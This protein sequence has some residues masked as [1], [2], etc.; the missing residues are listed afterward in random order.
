MATHSPPFSTRLRLAAV[1]A[2]AL[3]SLSVAG[4]GGS[5][6]SGTPVAAAVSDSGQPGS[7]DEAT[8]SDDASPAAI[9]ETAAYLQVDLGKLS[10]EQQATKV[11]TLSVRAR[12]SLVANVGPI[13]QVRVNGAVIGTVE[14][15][16]ADTWQDYSFSAPALKAGA[17]VDVVFDNDAYVNGVDRNLY[18]SAISDGRTL[19][20]PNTPIV[21]LDQ[22]SGAKA[23]DGLE[24]VPGR[25]ELWS[26][27]ALRTTWPST[28][29][30]T[31]AVRLRRQDASRFLMQTTFGPTAASITQLTK[32][33]YAS[34]VSAQMAL[35]VTDS[36]VAA[37]QTRYDRGP[38]FRPNGAQYS[39]YEVSRAFW[40][41]SHE[42]PDQL[43]RRVAYA[44]HQIFMVSQADSNLYHHSR[45]YARYLDL[46]NQHSFGNFRTLL[47]EMA[48]SPA[49][50]IYLSH[51]RNRKEDPA[52][53]RLPDE[54]F[55]REVMQ[56]FTIGLYELNPDGS[57]VRDAQGQPIETYNNADVMA[58]AK[59]FTGFS[60]AFPN[61]QLTEQKFRWGWPEYSASGD[62]RIDIL[63]MKAYPGQHSTAAKTLFAG[64]RW[65]VSM[66]AG[67]SAQDDLKAALDALFR[68]P[69]VGPFIG[70][71][72]IQKLVTSNPSPAYVARVSAVFNNNGQGVR[73]DL[74]AV[75]RAILLDTEARG[76]PTANFGKLREPVLRITQWRRAFNATSIDGSYNISWHIAPAG[77]RPFEAPS[78][79]GDFRPGYIP[80]NS[81]FAARGATAPEFQ[82]VNENTVAGW[83]NLAESMGSGG[84]GW[85]NNQR[86]INADYSALTKR[87]KAGQVAGML[88]DLDHWLFGSTMSAELRQIIID[89]ISGVQGN[90]DASQLNRARMAVFVA[91]A[92]P[93]FLI[94]R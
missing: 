70:R 35:P 24:V 38:T 71:Q 1:A 81:S 62:T 8:A 87:L 42:A 69:N 89:A 77:Q 31:D 46:L 64:K 66:P 68:H 47:E 50:G 56:L 45:A 27:G 80:P 33:T 13:M 43:R 14:V 37:V 7:S 63:P 16:N 53:D 58:L 91:M 79:F 74:G 44:L 84:L 36:F 51:M 17:K 23:F 34:W 61:N 60:W 12:G 21:K 54:N 65:A 85:S 4:C 72:L 41:T 32:Q 90:D 82:I 83:V 48:L 30:V 86:E 28:A 9:A 25:S 22:G 15:R 3:L 26:N 93:E 29:T 76:M 11:P 6:P 92:S 18:V 19:V 67:G 73:G 57:V 88:D 2:A 5:E 78:V 10:R 52:A 39:P 40:V 49:M 75:V 59:V 94:Q 20:L 55:A